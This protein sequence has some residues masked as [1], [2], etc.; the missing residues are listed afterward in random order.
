MVVSVVVVISHVPLVFTLGG[1]VEGTLLDCYVLVE[2]NGATLG[3]DFSW[4][5]AWVCGLVLPNTG[6]SV[7]LSEWDGA[8]TEVSLG[9]VDARV[10]IDLRAW[11]VTRRVVTVVDAI[12]DVDLGVGVPLVWLVVAKTG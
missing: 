6:S 4:V 9:N 3:V 7:L 1:S 8:V 2:R 5:G 10:E 12:L 11:G